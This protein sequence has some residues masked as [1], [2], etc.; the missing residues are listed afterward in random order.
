MTRRQEQ[1]VRLTSFRGHK[2]GRHYVTDVG[3]GASDEEPV[4]GLGNKLSVGIKPR[5]G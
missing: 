3:T 5:I 1:D 4:K 2:E